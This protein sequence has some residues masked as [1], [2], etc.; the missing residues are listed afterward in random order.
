MQITLQVEEV[1]R[2]LGLS[3]EAWNRCVELTPEPLEMNRQ[4]M[5]PASE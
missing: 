4:A 2:Q 1:I 3:L 5:E